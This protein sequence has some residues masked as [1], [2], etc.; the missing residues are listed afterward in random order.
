MPTAVVADPLRFLGRSRMADKIRAFDWSGNPLGPPEHWPPALKTALSIALASDFPMAI[1]WGRDLITFYNDAFTPIL[2]KKPEALGRPFNEV[3]SEHWDKIETLAAAAFE[4]RSTFVED[5]PL[6]VERQGYP[7]EAHFTLSYSPIRD[8][9]GQVVGMLDTVIETTAK[10]EAERQSRILNRELEHRIK[11][12]LAVVASIASHT[13]RRAE[14][15]EAAEQ[16]LMSRI[17]ALADSQRLL[18]RDAR[19]DA[20]ICELAKT[21]LAPH[22]A[23]KRVTLEGPRYNLPERPALAMALAVNELATNALKYGALSVPDGQVA[24]SWDVTFGGDR[25]TVCFRWIES[26]GPAVTLPA[27]GGFGTALL[28]R[29]VP[30]DFNGRA[31]LTYAPEGLRYELEGRILKAG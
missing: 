21:A 1:V 4:G 13:L 5:F 25:D 8:E 3:W 11:N 29:V 23:D 6:I 9:S 2:G 22:R 31:T 27:E 30:Q 24:V 18:T 17:S 20:D 26:G 7:E 19:A 14:T 15:L 28:Q 12:T 16:A 10:V